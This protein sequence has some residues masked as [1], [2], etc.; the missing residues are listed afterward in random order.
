MAKSTPPA[1]VYGIPN[2]D[3]VKK[4]LAW[5]KKNNIPFEFHDYKKEGVSKE[6]LQ[7]WC[8]LQPLDIILNKRSTAWK[9]LLPALQEKAATQAGA[10]QLMQEYNNLV[11][12]PVIE[13]SGTILIGFNEA[14]YKNDFKIS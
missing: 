14:S 4:S 8:A 13:I 3:T 12:R 10:I 1:I 9:E 5:L 11:K 2:C 6:K 7:E